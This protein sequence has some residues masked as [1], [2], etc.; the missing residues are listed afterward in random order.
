MPEIIAL[1]AWSHRPYCRLVGSEHHAATRATCLVVTAAV[2]ESVCALSAQSTIVVTG[3][4]G[5]LNSAVQQAMPGDRLIV[6]AG[7]YDA[8]LVDRGLLI[9]CDAGVLFA[10][11]VY[12]G[13]PS[14]IAG[15]PAGQSLVVRNGGIAGSLTP[16]IEIDRCAGIVTWIGPAFG[17]VPTQGHIEIT[18]CSSVSIDSPRFPLPSF[19]GSDWRITVDG[20]SASLSHCASCAPVF[21]R[22]STLAL[23]EVSVVES[24]GAPSLGAD[25]AVVTV[26]GGRFPGSNFWTG[27]ISLPGIRLHASELTITGGATATSGTGQSGL[28]G[29]IEGDAL[30]LVRIDPGVQLTAPGAPVQGVAAV[31]GGPIAFVDLPGQL[32]SGVPFG[33]RTHGAPGDVVFVFLDLPGPPAPTP[34]GPLWL[35]PTS[36]LFD[37]ATIPA[38]TTSTLSS[39]VTPPLP[40]AL[41]LV[42]QPIRLGSAGDVSLGVASRVLVNSPAAAR[43][44]RPT[45]PAGQAGAAR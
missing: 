11:D 13:G 42:F 15:V 24:Y 9:E 26:S 44:G 22:S 3:G 1:L 45:D 25:R 36:P 35:R 16:R 28:Q 43:R 34:L 8:L 20:S 29:A 23:D 21:A 5:A 32:R 38:A 17:E 31:H 6:R 40:A 10:A 12:H 4:G 27:Y 18:R 37:V 2:F 39:Y 30:S 41:P 7:R 19:H 33:L 14:R